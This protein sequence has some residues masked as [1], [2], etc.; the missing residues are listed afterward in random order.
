MRTTLLEQP[1]CVLLAQ[2]QVPPASGARRL[3][4]AMTAPAVQTA[5]APLSLQ[6]PDRRLIQCGGV[7]GAA[8]P[9]A[10]HGKDGVLVLLLTFVQTNTRRYDCGKLQALQELLRERKAVRLRLSRVQPARRHDLLTPPLWRGA[11]RRAGTA[12]S[13]SRR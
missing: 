5:P 6:F 12:C 8:L 2:L 11:R 10:R 4:G 9:L 7:L 13:S 1:A 3:R